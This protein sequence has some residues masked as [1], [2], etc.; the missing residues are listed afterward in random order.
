[1]ATVRA[2]FRVNRIVDQKYMNRESGQEVV[3]AREVQMSPVFSPE[4]G[5]ENRK[6]WTATPSGVLT[7][8]INNPEAYGQ[9]AV[10]QEYY[11]DFTPSE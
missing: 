5:S 3:S 9:F 10:G 4:E 7:M 6:F 11:L 1:M 8:W 2:K